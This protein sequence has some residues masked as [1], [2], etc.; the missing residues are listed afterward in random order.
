MSG[1]VTFTVKIRSRQASQKE[2]S[3]LPLAYWLA[4]WDAGCGASGE[5]MTRS[6]TTRFLPPSK[7]GGGSWRRPGAVYITIAR[8]YLAGLGPRPAYRNQRQH[9]LSVGLAKGNARGRLARR[10]SL[11]GLLAEHPTRWGADE[12]CS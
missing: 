10:R 6:S 12:H 1:A 11:G 3:A 8:P 7:D 9:A 5:V 4:R 2:A